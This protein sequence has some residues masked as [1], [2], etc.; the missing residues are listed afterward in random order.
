MEAGLMH[1]ERDDRGDYKNTIVVNGA[2]IRNPIREEVVALR[3]LI[4]GEYVVNVNHY[5][6]TTPDPVP[7]SVKVE[8]INPKVE[9]VYYERLILDHTGDEKTAVRFTIGR[10][11]QGHRH[12]HAPEVLDPRNPQGPLEY[13]GD[14]R[15]PAPITPWDCRWLA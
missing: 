15:C 4:A 1:L 8:K 12:Q 11:R 10:G 2:T 3:G 7:V 6:A 14:R 5:L 13:P 9:V